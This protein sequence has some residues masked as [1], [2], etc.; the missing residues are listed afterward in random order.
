[1]TVKQEVASRFSFYVT[2]SCTC[3]ET[4]MAEIYAS[5]LYFN[6]K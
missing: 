5:E 4:T 2:V 1:M 6:C 3:I